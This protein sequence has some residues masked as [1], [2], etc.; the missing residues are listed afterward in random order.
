MVPSGCLRSLAG[1]ARLC[2]VCDL[3]MESDQH[4]ALLDALQRIAEALEAISDKQGV[5]ANSLLQLS[6][7]HGSDVPGPY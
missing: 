3:L 4:E 1:V 5:I 7:E 6:D 2:K